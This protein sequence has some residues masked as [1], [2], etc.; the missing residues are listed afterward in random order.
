[1]PK[2]NRVRA[3]A[4]RPIETVAR[5]ERPE[6]GRHERALRRRALTGPVRATD[7]PSPVLE[8]AATAEH[9]YVMRDVR[10]LAIV[11]A[12]MTALLV[13]S[14]FGVDRLLR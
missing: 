4:R 1:M 7:E 11:A 6:S 12:V 8:R 10:R 2:R 9:T 3:R 13:A 5:A 14:G